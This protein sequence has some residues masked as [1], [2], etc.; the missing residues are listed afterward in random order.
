MIGYT[1]GRIMA[2]LETGRRRVLIQNVAPEIDAGEFPIKRIVGQVVVVSADAL[3]DGHDQLSCILRHRRAD[4][5]LWSDV[6]MESLGNDRWRGEFR[7]TE[8]GRYRYTV[9]AWVDHFKSWQETLRK[10]LEAGQQTAIELK[11][12]AQLVY[13]ASQRASG[14]KAEQLRASAEIL[15][16]ADLS[17]G[18]EVGL[19]DQLRHQMADYSDRRL[20]T[21]YSKE[22][23]VV[24]DRERAACGS[25]YEMF[26]RSCSP[27]AGRHGTFQDCIHRLP[28][29][30]EMG[31]DVLY[32]PPIHPIGHTHRKGRNGASE[33][34]ADDPGSPWAIGAEEGGHKAVHPEL[35]TLEDFDCL[36]ATARGHGLEIAL[37]LAYQCSPDHPYVREHPEWFEH[38]P[39]GSVQYAENPPKKYEDIYPFDFETD[40]WRELWQELLDI[41]VF[42][43]GHGVRIFRVDNP[44]TKPFPFWRW[45]IE[46]IQA[47][48]PDVLFLAEAFTRPKVMYD[49]AK[50][51]FSQSYTYFTWRNTKEQLTRYFLELAQTETREFFRPNLWPNTP[52]ILTEYLQYGGRPAFLTR[53]VLAATLSANYGIY[54]PAY[55]LVETRARESGSEEY[56]DSEKYQIRHWDVEGS[57]NLKEFIRRINRIRRENAAL[58]R[59]GNLRFHPVDNDQ[60]LC[61]SRQSEN[62]QN[63]VLVA[64]NLDPHHVQSGFVELP[65]EDLGIRSDQ[66][67]QVHDLLGG[68]RYLW[69]GFRNYV[70]LNPELAPAHILLIRRRTRSEQQLEYFM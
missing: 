70:Q 24:V 34:A 52:D 28:Y 16:R 4:D 55:E 45:L 27:D 59:D 17:E 48:H 37:D 11:V 61:Y 10:R 35:G 63:T 21:T 18:I 2:I 47:K 64:V 32:L 66:P 20:S 19:S 46:E 57:D 1:G 31:F 43:I 68:G 44:H 33:V 29:I 7:V 6:P 58:Q 65:L 5:P 56:W 42:W 49:L 12:G 9:E 39:D 41:A 23:E 54:G 13:R 14:P 38:R 25:W 30:A 62:R 60:L 50:L 8:V 15:E 26:P 3:T 22:L 36:V 51:G 40:A 53:L 67:Y 69:Q